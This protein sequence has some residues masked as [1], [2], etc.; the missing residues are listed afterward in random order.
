VVEQLPAF[1]IQADVPVLLM[2]F[3]LPFTVGVLTGISSAYVAVTFPIL[4]GLL[5]EINLS[6]MAF[7]Y[8]SGFAGVMVTPIH[9]CMVF[10][11]N[12]YKAKL[13]SLMVRV[14][15]PQ[16]VLIAFAFILTVR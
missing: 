6:Y 8:V 12:Y 13:G 5:P 16:F 4:A 15:I 11:A 14:M 7:A 10:S 2:F 3:L 9:L 1:L